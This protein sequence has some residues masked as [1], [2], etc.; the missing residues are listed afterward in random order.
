VFSPELPHQFRHAP[1]FALRLVRVKSLAQVV[2]D[3]LGFKLQQHAVEQRELLG[4][5]PLD[6]LVQDGLELLRRDRVGS[7]VAFHAGTIHLQTPPDKGV[8]QART[9]DKFKPLRNPCGGG[10]ICEDELAAAL[11]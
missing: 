7:A 11:N 1:E 2:G 9:P 8:K 5:H 10:G 6:F 3:L 4:I